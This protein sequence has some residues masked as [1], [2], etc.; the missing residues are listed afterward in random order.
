MTRQIDSVR[1]SPDFARALE[2]ARDQVAASSGLESASSGTDAADRAAESLRAG[3]F[4]EAMS[5]PQEARAQ[6]GLEAIILAK[7]R[8]AY[9]ILGDQIELDGDYDH[10]GLIEQQ[11][12]ALEARARNVGRVDLIYHPSLPFGGTGWLVEKDIVVTNRHVADLF[13]LAGRTGPLDFALGEFGRKIEA[14]LDTLQQRDDRG[15]QR[16]PARVREILYIAGPRE[17]D[18]ALLRIDPQDGLEA[19]DLASW[20]AGV[21]TPVAAVG[22]PASDLGRNP[23]P[24]LM[25]QYFGTVFDVKRFSPG[26]VTALA[27]ADTLVLCDYTSLG[28]SSGSP[29]LDLATGKV[30]GLHFA[31]V[32]RDTNYA[33]AADLVKAAVT[34]VRTIVAQRSAGATETP[35]TSAAQLAERGGYD[36]DFLGEGALA[37]PLPGL[38]AHQEDAAPVSDDPAGR[39]NYTHFTVIQ[40]RSRRLPR[41]TAVN[42][43]GG[44]AFRLKR[45]GEWR[46]DGRIAE[47]HQIGNELY[48]RNPFDRGHMVRR[49]DPGWGETEAEAQQGELDTFH[50]TNSAPQHENLNQKDWVGL[51][52]Y[53]MEAA[54]TRDFKVSVFT[55]PVFREGDLRLKPGIGST[56]VQ[57]P[58]EFWKVAVMVNRDTERLS[59]T[60]YVLSQGLMIRDLTEAAFVLGEYATYQVQIGRIEAATGLDFSYLRPFDPL[61]AATESRFGA[62][63]FR[64]SGPESLKL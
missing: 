11:K 53:I 7:L 58:E 59:A 64:I 29:V 44:R 54:E 21:G 42:I 23:N 24:A 26:L 19:L 37:V 31:G 13:A 27:E 33:V 25:A 14:R 47:E 35:A 9:L 34:R 12:A 8:P 48:A 39:L 56:E 3:G 5:S 49:R 32:F 51:E 43:D 60:G 17:P 45:E 16:D 40:S 41:L 1:S 15:L 38:G 28:G 50:Y 4:T 30:V 62:A 2:E 46:F 63:A 36:P 52:D 61:A 57:I 10:R 55:G 6:L 18:V 20:R 22:Y